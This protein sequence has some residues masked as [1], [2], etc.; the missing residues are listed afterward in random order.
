MSE[1]RIIKNEDVHFQAGRGRTY[2]G[3]RFLNQSHLSAVAPDFVAQL[4]V[5]DEELIDLGLEE[6]DQKGLVFPVEKID[7]PQWQMLANRPRFEHKGRVLEFGFKDHVEVALKTLEQ[8]KFLFENYKILLTDRN[9]S[10]I[11]LRLSEDEKNVKAWKY[12]VYQVDFASVYDAENGTSVIAD[13]VDLEKRSQS[14]QPGVYKNPEV[15]RANLAIQMRLIVG[16]VISVAKQ[17]WISTTL[18]PEISKSLTVFENEWN[19]LGVSQ[20][21]GRSLD[22]ETAQEFLTLLL[23]DFT[24]SSGSEELN[25]SNNSSLPIEVIQKSHTLNDI[26]RMKG[27]G[28]LFERLV[29][30][31]KSKKTDNS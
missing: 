6:F 18:S 21:N 4:I 22:F 16:H 28:K 1:S 13:D 23:N 29:S 17:E 19:V 14:P 2:E 31:F 5:P 30:Y 27:P 11:V 3:E 9:E 12:K 10:N 7:G 20:R 8:M 26:F 25:P 15:T 24:K